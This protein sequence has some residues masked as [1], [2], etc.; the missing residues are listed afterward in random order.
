MKNKKQLSIK[1]LKVESFVTSADELNSH[2]LRGGQESLVNCGS[3]GTCGAATCLESDVH[4]VCCGGSG[5]DSIP[6]IICGGD[7][8]FCLGGCHAY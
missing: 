8:T 1:D 3:L 2:T 6:A 7:V 5:D 4:T